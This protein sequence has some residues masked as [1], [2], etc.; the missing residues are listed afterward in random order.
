[1]GKHIESSGFEVENPNS[2]PFCRGKNSA[3]QETSPPPKMCRWPLG[4]SLPIA[5]GPK[6]PGFF[7]YLSLPS[8]P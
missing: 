8:F 4:P 7:P 5:V 1:M 3:G 6:T 2:S